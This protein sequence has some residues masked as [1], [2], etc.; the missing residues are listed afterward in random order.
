MYS[1]VTEPGEG[2]HGNQRHLVCSLAL[3]MC[4]RLGE[5]R[6]FSHSAKNTLMKR[7]FL[8][9]YLSVKHER[10]HMCVMCVIL[11]ESLALEMAG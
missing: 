1:G 4:S 8:P 9:H 10:S 3:L 2:A 5:N 7:V 6:S 11:R